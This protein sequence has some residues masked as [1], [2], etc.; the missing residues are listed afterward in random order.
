MPKVPFLHDDGNVYMVDTGKID[1]VHCYYYLH[2][3][4][5]VIWKPAVV[6]QIDPEYFNSPF[7]KKV[8]TIREEGDLF[9]LMCDLREMNLKLPREGLYW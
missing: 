1:G 2:E 8:W 5:T 3:N 9:N 6:A 7:V 4:D